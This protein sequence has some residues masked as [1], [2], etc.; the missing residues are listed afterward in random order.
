MNDEQRLRELSDFLQSRR[1]RLSPEAVGF[2][3]CSR[4]RTPGLR[5]EEV[6]QLANVSTT[7]YTFLEQGRD[8]RVSIQVLENTVRALQLNAAE[9]THLFLLAL[10]QMP[11]DLP[12]S[13]ESVNPALQN[14]LDSFAG[15]AYISSSRWDALAWN[16]PASLLFGDF[17]AMPLKQRNILWI[18]FTNS[19]FRQMLLDWEDHAEIMVANFRSSASRLVGDSQVAELIEDLQRVSPEFQALWHRHDV[20]SRMEGVKVYEHPVVGRL[21]FEYA[22]FWTE[23]SSDLRLVTLAP[24]PGTGTADKLLQLTSR[25]RFSSSGPYFCTHR[26]MVM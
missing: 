23:W 6:A 3:N 14:F 5:R 20:K 2:P 18:Y 13:Q 15:P 8:V 17:D 16:L 12:A 1:A 24:V 22:T 19:K 25:Q 4:R 9:R 26:K 10:Q 21:V 7:W 11:P